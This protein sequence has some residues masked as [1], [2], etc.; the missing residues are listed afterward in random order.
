METI[1]E[2]IIEKINIKDSLF[3]KYHIIHKDKYLKEDSDIVF[4]IKQIVLSLVIYFASS[5]CCISLIN[6]MSIAWLFSLIITFIV[7]YYTI[8]KMKNIYSTYDKD[9]VLSEIKNL[10]IK[11]GRYRKIKQ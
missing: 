8:L 11:N 6:D 5:L 3:K 7:M 2:F 4:K 10:I 9:L 1:D